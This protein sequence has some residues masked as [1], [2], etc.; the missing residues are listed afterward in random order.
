MLPVRIAGENGRPDGTAPGSWTTWRSCAASAIGAAASTNSTAAVRIGLPP[1]RDGPPG[2]AVR[3]EV[4]LEELAETVQRQRNR[5]K[6][7]DRLHDLVG[8]LRRL[9]RNDEPIAGAD[10]Q[11]V[12]RAP[13]GD[14][15]LQ[16]AAAVEH[17][18]ATLDTDQVELRR[19]D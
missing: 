7:L 13:L 19:R 2:G 18:L 12:E 14:H 8:V 6:D 11:R 16:V 1:G 5:Q 10:T 9:H 4:A 3:P 15:S 17:L